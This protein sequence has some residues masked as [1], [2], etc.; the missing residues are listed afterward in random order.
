M[1][2]N[3]KIGMRLS[4]AF[5]ALV[6]LVVMLAVIAAANLWR[7]KQATDAATKR[8]WPEAHAIAAIRTD[9]AQISADCRDILLSK[10]AAQTALLRGQIRGD[11]QHNTALIDDFAA[12]VA[13]PLIRDRLPQL[14]SDRHAFSGAITQCLASQQQG[15][16][17]L[18]LFDHDVRPAEL[19]VKSDLKAID[20]VAVARFAQATTEADQAFSSALTIAL[21]VAAAAVLMALALG[22]SITRSITRPLAEAVGVARRVADGDLTVRAQARSRDETGQLLGALAEM[23]ARLT[24]TLSAVR[25]AADQLSS[26][27]AQVSSTSQS[28]AQGASEQAAS[29]EETSATLEQ[30]AASVKG[31]ADNARLTAG[32]AQQASQQASDGGAAVARTVADMQAIAERIGIVDDIA[33]QTNM[34]ALNAAIEA[35][36]AGEH[37][38]GFA[39]VAAEVRK[40]AERAQV[41]AR[42][43]GELATGSVRQAEAAGALL[44][45]LVPAIA[46][47][48][49]LVEEINA[50]SD[51]QAAGIGQI[52]QAV[53][54]LNATTQQ[55][56]SASEQLAATAEEMNGQAT[57]LQN[58][59][60]R[61]RLDADAAANTVIAAAAPPATN[62]AVAGLA[63]AAASF[64]RF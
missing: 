32:I 62:R 7:M 24:S 21:A 37:G 5:G 55:S 36:R 44:G 30:A 19:A 18:T 31:N 48:S 42:E 29:V 60:A 14:D 1:F 54:Q 25:A 26:A 47:T 49:E 3:L 22:W 39:V 40:L 11:L 51:E 38:K 33:Y 12:H 58:Q 28:L 15:G 23:V 6:L 59:V 63:P 13:N 64:V 50:A 8:A 9:L 27:S 46:R 56:A 53:A 35:A 4:L 16:D 45:Q 20:T 10:D 34:L 17:A 43:I 2:Q 41:A 61:F 57:E 52:N